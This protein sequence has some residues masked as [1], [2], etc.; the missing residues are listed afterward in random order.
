MT[1]PVVSPLVPHTGRRNGVIA[2]NSKG[3][4]H[5][6]QAYPRFAIISAGIISV[7]LNL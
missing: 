6:R 5:S 7:A 4:S 3:R 2:A 1:R